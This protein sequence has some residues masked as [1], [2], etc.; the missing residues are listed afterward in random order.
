M[1][2]AKKSFKEC[3]DC[4]I[5]VAEFNM[6]QGICISCDKPNIITSPVEK[7]VSSRTFGVE[8]EV[9][10]GDVDF[11]GWGRREDGSLNE[12]WEF[13]SP[14]FKGYSEP[15]KMIKDFCKAVKNEGGDIDEE[16]GFHLHI[17]R[18]K[19]PQYL[20]ENAKAVEK[21]VFKIVDSGRYDSNYCYPIEDKY[22]LKCHY[23]WINESYNHPTIEIRAH[24]G[25]LDPVRIEK[26]IDLW[27]SFIECSNIGKCNGLLDAMN[28]VGTRKSTVKYFKD[29]LKS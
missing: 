22:S 25:T 8:F 5:E 11:E 28:K 15:I 29:I 1:R 19:T 6:N 13:V 26:W 21:E 18:E 3:H 2:V 7:F 17:G 16:C 23:V 27:L 4:G 9:K 12:G 14:I 24:E 20:Y 10:V